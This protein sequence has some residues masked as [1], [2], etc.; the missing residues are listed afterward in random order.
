[1]AG[2]IKQ[3]WEALAACFE[4]NEQ[5]LTKAQVLAWIGS[6][7]PDSEFNPNTVQAQLYR[8]CIN[9]PS[10]QGFNTPKILFYEKS[11]RTYLRSDAGAS[12]EG[13]ASD[14]STAE[15]GIDTEDPDGQSNATFALEA[16][17]RD[18]LARNL[19]TL[20]K[21]LTLWSLNPPS[22]EYVVDNRRIDV[23]A[24]DIQGNP[25]V[26]ELKLSK[27]YD[28]V[29]GQA[30]LYQGLVSKKLGIER[31]RIILVAG[32]ISDELKIASARQ[33]DVLLFEY[34][35]TMQISKVSSSL[36]EDS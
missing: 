26:I 19:S 14:V 33:L 12:I 23:L 28:R 35:I 15:N 10:V 11:N 20:E 29:I 24:K 27:A 5:P 36:L 8:S 1:M 31:V 9:V 17:L 3:I 22:V 21:G 6:T 25:V 2:K 4:A 13:A 30:L 18:F 34:A 7:Y 32:E 16:H